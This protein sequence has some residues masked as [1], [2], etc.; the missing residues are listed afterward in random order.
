MFTA[1]RTPASWNRH[2]GFAKGQAGLGHGAILP[3]I[4]SHNCHKLRQLR[5]IQADGWSFSSVSEAFCLEFLYFI[6]AAE[7]MFH[8]IVAARYRDL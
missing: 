6:L 7:F 8:H 4:A 2:G 5:K 1:P 3:I